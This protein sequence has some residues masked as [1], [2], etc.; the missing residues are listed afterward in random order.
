MPAPTPL[1]TLR[2]LPL[3]LRHLRTLAEQ[4]QAT[5]TAL[6]I[7]ESFDLDPTQVRKDLEPIGCPGIKKVGYPVRDLIA[8]IEE[9]LGWNNVN[10]AFLVGAGHLGTA[11][12][13]YR[14]FVQSGIHLVAAFDNDTAR[15]GATLHGRPV[16]P[17]AKLP[18]L[19][20]R[21]HV[22]LGVLAVNEDSA[23]AAATAMRAAGL[24]A[25][26][27]F[28]PVRLAFDDLIVE[29]V[30]LAASL[31]VLSRRLVTRAAANHE[32]QP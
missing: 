21:M 24:T 32:T 12:L 7:A 9:F 4:E 13:G 15:I 16:Y 1:P 25:I 31:A 17:M 11:L 19:V 27:N 29:D 28:T 23:L 30:D 2:R 5:V 22:R 10:D 18:E 26:W 8:A 14:G 20:T 6:A 3:Y